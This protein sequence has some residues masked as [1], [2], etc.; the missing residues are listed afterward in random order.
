MG[1]SEVGH[2]A[3]GSGRVLAQGALLVNEAIASGA[4]PLR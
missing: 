1:N 3:I 2:N 4:I